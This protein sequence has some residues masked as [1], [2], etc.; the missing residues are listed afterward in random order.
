MKSCDKT[1]CLDCSNK[2]WDI[3]DK[4]FGDYFFLCVS[5][6]NRLG[7]LYM[8]LNALKIKIV[9]EDV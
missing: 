4:P 8:F 1:L 6:R 9:A 3:K 5:S 2:K 7:R